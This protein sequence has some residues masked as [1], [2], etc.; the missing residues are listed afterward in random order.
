MTVGLKPRFGWA[1]SLDVGLVL[2]L[3]VLGVAIFLP[4]LSAVVLIDHDDVISVISATCNQARFEETAPV[5]RWVSAGD[6]QQFW[7]FHSFGCFGEITRG[8]NHYDI[9]PPFYFW[10]LHIWFGLFGVSILSGLLLNLVL[11]TITAG[12]VYATC[13]I[14]SVSATVSFVV[15]MVWMF[16]LPSRMTI[17]VLRQYTLF[18]ALVALLLLFVVLWLK[19]KQARHLF[20]ISIVLAAGLLTHYQFPIPAGLTLLFAAAILFRRNARTQTVQLA[21]AAG[22]AAL[23][24]VACNPGFLESIA[25]ARARAQPFTLFSSLQRVGAVVST[26]FQIFNPFDWTHPLPYGLL[27]IKS[28]LDIA[29]NL[30]NVVV[31]FAGLYLVASI[32]RRAWRIH[33][34]PRAAV[35]SLEYLPI[36][37]AVASWSFVV[38]LY[39]LCVSP[40]H[41][42][43]LQY[44]HFVSP[45]LF[46][47]IAQAAQV[48]RNSISD[49][50]VK[51]VAL[52]T[53][54]CAI[55]A[56]TLFAV[57]R[58]EQQRIEV[59]HDADT[60]ILDSARIGIL[61][62]VLWHADKEAMV[63]A[64]T[65]Q[66]QLLA[67]FPTVGA[68]HRLYYV[69][70]LFY[71]NTAENRQRILDHLAGLGYRS[72]VHH[73]SGV[74]P[75]VPLGGDIYALGQ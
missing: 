49:R 6:W 67:D 23:I 43:G 66:E 58:S 68:G 30:V 64:V 15:T 11:L 31:G 12:V 7:Q 59:V 48:C 56:T 2:L 28:P 69:N 57:H 24:F 17:S 26:A 54:V 1:V 44:M 60:I 72:L 74:V 38:A 34:G 47:G 18:T 27:D 45:C 13:R 71:G 29:I 41:A 32:I 50:T 4:K 5:G 63:Y 35:I 19:R 75:L 22:A 42:I 3:A 9:H 51:F 62:T 52:T 65:G 73:P 39:I 14:L 36:F 37:V 25:G 8:L 55:G 46:V 61:P 40:V 70:S 33:T 10:V 21:V 16:V 53:V 20:A